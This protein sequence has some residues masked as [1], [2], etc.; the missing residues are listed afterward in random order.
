MNS[1][2]CPRTA[3]PSLSQVLIMGWASCG[4]HPLHYLAELD[5]IFLRH[6]TG[7][8]GVVGSNPAAPTIH[9]IHILQE[10]LARMAC[11]N[12]L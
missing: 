10:C 7:G 3:C 12:V 11:R 4:L 9:F 5:P 8:E 6:I 2:R 1:Y